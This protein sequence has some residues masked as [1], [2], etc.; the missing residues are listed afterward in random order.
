MVLVGSL[1]L[2]FIWMQA[3]FFLLTGYYF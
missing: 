3:A 1:K 2:M